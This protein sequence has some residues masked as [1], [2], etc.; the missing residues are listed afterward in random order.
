MN[1]VEKG[2][3]WQRSQP[4]LSPKLPFYWSVSAHEESHDGAAL[5]PL[6]AE[7]GAQ[8][9]SLAGQVQQALGE[10]PARAGFVRLLE[11]VEASKCRRTKHAV[12]AFL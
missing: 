7:G 12:D 8:E 11:L 2:R 9:L 3:S 10:P 4:L 6:F 1:V 5:G